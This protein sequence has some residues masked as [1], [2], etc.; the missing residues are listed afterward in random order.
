MWLL[1][2]LR[3]T[4][5]AYGCCECLADSP[6]KNFPVARRTAQLLTAKYKLVQIS[7]VLVKLVIFDFETKK[8]Q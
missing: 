5:G 2:F 4:G 7:N 6:A 8:C 1:L 3:P